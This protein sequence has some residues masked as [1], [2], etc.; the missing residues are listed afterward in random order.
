MLNDLTQWLEDRYEVRTLASRFL[1]RRIPKG[2]SWFHCLGSAT[3]FLLLIQVVTG[4]FLAVYYVPSPEQAFDSVQYITGQVPFGF[5][6]RGIHRWSASLVVVMV[7]LHLLGVFFMAAYKYPRELTWVVGV[8]LLVL[9]MG[10]GFTGYLLPY[11][12]KAYWATVVGAHLVEK[13]PYIGPFL[14]RLV[15]AGPEP[16]PL[17]LSRFYALHTLFLPLL[18]YTL[19]GIHVAMV[20]KQGI[21]A[22]PLDAPVR[23]GLAAGQSFLSNVFRG[24]RSREEY[25]RA[26][27]ASKKDGPN[28]YE[29]LLKDAVVALILLILVIGLT[30]Y[31]GIPTEE[32]A[33]P[34][35]VNYVPRPEWYFYFLFEMLWFFP[36]DWIVFPTVLIPALGMMAL[37]MLPFVDRGWSW[38]PARRPL[39]TA[40][41]TMSLT[42]V[43]FLTYRGATAPL[44][45]APTMLSLPPVVLQAES[46]SPPDLGRKVYQQQGCGSCHSIGGVG[47]QAGPDLS[48]VGSRRDAESLRTYIRDPRASNPK[49][50][51]PPY[52]IPNEELDA[53]VAYLVT[54]R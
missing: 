15:E 11:D 37:I 26:Y 32:R 19:A 1:E 34:A 21:S 36:G 10:F 22:P 13:A 7:V 52:N 18:L 54:L 47:A 50:A 31:L 3:L 5:L 33:N 46:S 14:N 8:F 28:F 30:S 35:D 44:P 49:S 42:V 29:H 23:A 9:V 2:I 43:L 41:A 12:Q 51:M 27:E 39:A 25:K 20:I 6:V 40:M 24:I 16:G 38:H 17:T 53:L 48:R 4:I 45:P